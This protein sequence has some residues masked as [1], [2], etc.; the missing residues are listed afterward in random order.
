MGEI[1]INSNKTLM[2]AENEIETLKQNYGN[3]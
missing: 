3:S 2:K 1:N